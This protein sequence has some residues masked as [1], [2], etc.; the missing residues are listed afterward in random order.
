MHVNGKIVPKEG[1]QGSKAIINI[2]WHKTTRIWDTMQIKGETGI[3]MRRAGT[4]TNHPI[5]SL[6]GNPGR[7]T[8]MRMINQAPKWNQPKYERTIRMFNSLVMV[9]KLTTNTMTRVQTTTVKGAT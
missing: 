2:K 7:Y 1:N 8:R 3:H 9:S 6:R 5:C 4:I